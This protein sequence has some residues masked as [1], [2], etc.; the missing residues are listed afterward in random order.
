MYGRSYLMWP[1]PV[2]VVFQEPKLN[3]E[4][5]SNPRALPKKERKRLLTVAVCCA[6]YIILVS[7]SCIVSF[8]MVREELD[9][10]D[11]TR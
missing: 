6:L 10:T 11:P 4:H 9:Q 1:P 7:R 8:E 3:V 5:H 2:K